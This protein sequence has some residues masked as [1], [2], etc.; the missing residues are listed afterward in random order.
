[1]FKNMNFSKKIMLMMG[2][3]SIIIILVIGFI[4][5]TMLKEDLEKRAEAE[6]KQ[7][8]DLTYKL[9]EATVNASI[10]NYLRAIADKTR[11]M[12]EY[13]YSLYQN[14]EISQTEAYKKTEDYILNPYVYRI[15]KTGYTAANKIDGRL[16]IHP[17]SPN[18]DASNFD[19]MK[20][21]I[22]MKDGYLEY[23]WKNLEGSEFKKKAGYV[24]YFEP[25]KLLIWPSAYKKEFYDLI[26]L[27]EIRKKILS[28]KLRKTGY[29]YIL[30]KNTKLIV[31]P[32]LEG[33][34]T[35]DYQDKNGFF[36]V[37]EMMKEKNGKITYWWRKNDKEEWR[38][39]IVYYKHNEKLDWL[40]CSGVYLD[41]LY[42]P[43]YKVRNVVIFISL[44]VLILVFFL[45]ILMGKSVSKPVKEL[46]K[47]AEKIGKGDLDIKLDIGTSDEI[48]ELAINF[49]QMAENLKK[50]QVKIQSQAKELKQANTELEDKVKERTK[51][52]EEA[53]KTA[54]EANRAKSTFLGNMSHEIRTPLTSILGNAELLAPH[55]KDNQHAIFLNNIKT[56]IKTLKDFIDNTLHMSRIEAKKMKIAIEPVNIYAI[57]NEI[58]GNFSYQIDQKKLQY[59]EGH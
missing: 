29:M 22:K 23:D 54:E 21:A 52:I 36:F 48:G 35:N 1:M 31:H 47:G 15:G 41:E 2:F 20:K 45:S 11:D 56:S 57:L 19:F 30:D 14:G 28:C 27:K 5:Y 33:K 6:L 9:I 17:F 43:V 42:E 59:I 3:T 4:T 38:E 51:E 7:I 12:V 32:D 8:N 34:V 25:W 13:F 10:E 16:V 49:N 46:A 26:N 37:Q 53:R 58:H 44:I 24:R 40:I 39:E 55:I 50:S 18:F